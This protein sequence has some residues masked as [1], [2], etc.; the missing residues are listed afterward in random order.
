M[1]DDRRTFIVNA[2][3]L[4]S[5]VAGS[6]LVTMR[7]AAAATGFIALVH[8]QAAGD[9]GPVDSMIASLAQAGVKNGVTTRAIFGQDPAT[10]ESTLRTLCDVGASIVVVTFPETTNALKAVAPRYPKTK[11]IHLFADP[12]VPT[13]PNV[14]TVS[15]DY[16][17]G[18]YLSGRFGAAISKSRKL[19]HIAGAPQPPIIADYNAMKAAASA[20]SPPASV[21]D[22]VAGSFQD[23]AKGH[24]IAVQMYQSGIDFIQTD[25]AATDTGIVQAAGEG[26]G[27]LV[28]V[29]AAAQL[30]LDPKVVV[31][32]V[33]LDFG[34]S[35]SIE[36]AKALSPSFTGG[37][38]RTGLDGDVIDFVLS[39]A[40]LTAGD[41]PAVAAAR[42]AW[43]MIEDTK[44]KILAGS[45]KVPFSTVSH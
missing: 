15:Y 22:A 16:Y 10:Y 34:R 33:K 29:G 17:L 42:R 27:R 24:E 5:A 20:A 41:K 43:P 36:V 39:D 18:C 45:T 2:F 14:R 13:M 6:E 12:I 44:R 25:S 7:A 37:H 30:K 35:L 11:F 8:T 21:T 23:P 38:T 19:G 3:G 4:L 40:F 26:A 1:F 28:S 9:N 32:M 31:S